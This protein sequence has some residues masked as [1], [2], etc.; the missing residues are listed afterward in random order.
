MG[1]EQIKVDLIDSM[2]TDLTVCK[3]ARVSFDKESEWGL[4]WVGAEAGYYEKSLKEKDRKLV[5]Y[6]AEH[7][8]F[9]PFGH[10]FASF[11]VTAPIFVARQLVKHE[12]LRMNEISRRYVDYEPVFYFPEDWRQKAK[13]K[14]QGSGE[15][16]EYQ[17][18][19][20]DDYSHMIEYSMALYDDMIAANVA[21]EMARMVLPQSMLT[22]WYWSGSMD[23]L[24]NMVNLRIAKDTQLETQQVAKQIDVYMRD[25]YPVSWVALRGE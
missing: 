11:R 24:A 20:K 12:Y 6:L 25:L 17:E 3:S 14:K 2:G 8:H 22:S 21:P 1:L 13:D 16:L 7:N 23:A 5:N 9:S 4:R 10:C 18:G 19:L 15:P